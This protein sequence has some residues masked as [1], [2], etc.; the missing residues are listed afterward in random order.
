M[1][2]NFKKNTFLIIIFVVIFFYLIF[3]YNKQNFKYLEFVKKKLE[4]KE[5]NNKLE[6]EK[7]FG[8][9]VRKKM[10]G[11]DTIYFYNINHIDYIE[12]EFTYDSNGKII[13]YIFPN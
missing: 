2:L 3:K 13:N 12:A 4:K 5:I 8:L 11:N 7:I 10:F 6:I 1:N 9:C